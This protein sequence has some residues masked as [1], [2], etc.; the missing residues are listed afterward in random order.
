MANRS[1]KLIDGSLSDTYSDIKDYSSYSMWLKHSNTS[2]RLSDGGESI[3]SVSIIARNHRLMHHRNSAQ[4]P[5]LKLNRSNSIRYLKAQSL[6][7]QSDFPIDITVC[8]K[9][10]LMFK[11]NIRILIIS[12]RR[13]YSTATYK[14]GHIQGREQTI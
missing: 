7:F 14:T 1:G 10:L 12:L 2:S 5:G 13:R 6:M 9:V 4:S 11:F 8:V 3:D